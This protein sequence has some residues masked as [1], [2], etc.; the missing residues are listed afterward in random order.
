MPHDAETRDVAVQSVLDG[1]LSYCHCGAT[2]TEGHT[3][4]CILKQV[5][6]RKERSPTASNVKL[7]NRTEG[8]EMADGSRPA[9]GSEQD[10]DE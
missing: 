1:E 8:Q 10:Q 5:E 3:L 4:S 6:L 7:T 9:E 2:E